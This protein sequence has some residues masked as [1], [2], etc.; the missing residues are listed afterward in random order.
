M[1]RYLHLHFAARRKLTGTFDTVGRAG[2]TQ[3][4]KHQ[5]QRGRTYLRRGQQVLRKRERK[6]KG[7]GSRF[8]PPIERPQLHFLRKE[9]VGLDCASADRG[10]SV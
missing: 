7:V 9:L 8:Y 5:Q 2:G 10:R 1:H 6:R 3:L 4:K